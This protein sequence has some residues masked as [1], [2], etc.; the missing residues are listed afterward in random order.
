MLEDISGDNY[1]YILDDDYDA[2]QANILERYKKY[3]EWRELSNHKCQMQQMRM[4][5]L[6][7]QQTLQTLKI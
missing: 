6:H 2:I 7:K 3:N 5:I 1:N 4:G